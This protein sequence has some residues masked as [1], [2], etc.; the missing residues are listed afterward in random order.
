[1]NKYNR[2]I[3][4]LGNFS[5]V[6]SAASIIAALLVNAIPAAPV[7]AGTAGTIWTTNPSCLPSQDFMN[8]NTG[9]VVWVRG[10]GFA[11]STSLNWEVSATGG[12]TGP[13]GSP[14]FG[15]VTTDKDGYFCEGFY[16]VVSGD[17]GVFKFDVNG[18]HDA[19][20]VN[21]TTPTETTT[22]TDTVTPTDT[23]TETVT[24]TDTPTE[25]VT[26]T[27]TPTETV[28]PTDTPTETVTPTDT[29]TET[30][31]PT[32][33]PT[34]T[35][36]PTDTPTETVTPTDT[37]TETVTPTDTPTETVTPTDTPTVTE[38]P[39][40]TVTPPPGEDPVDV[41][42]NCTSFTFINQNA[43]AVEGSWTIVGTNLSGTFNLA[44]YDSITVNTGFYSGDLNIV[45]GEQSWSVAAATSC[46]GNQ[47]LIPVTGMDT[48]LPGS[49]TS[50]ILFL[51]SI[52]FLGMGLVL[53]GLDRK[54]KK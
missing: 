11:V 38:T 12:A 36:T 18:K 20:K 1:M 50:R 14:Y 28:T 17:S 16:T 8:Y 40:E 22:P 39:T 27:D 49:F 2:F 6:L 29:P 21:D 13:F 44:A 33:T 42:R 48:T 10:A 23:P 52:S 3:R 30:V 7:Y 19:F 41:N 5:Y 25:T 24:P 15:T 47:I 46:G 54:N 31:T 4:K 37:P 53:N 43:F 45:Q 32:D 51:A 34:E 35:V 26:P 9:E